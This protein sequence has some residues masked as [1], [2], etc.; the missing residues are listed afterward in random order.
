MLR[1]GGVRGW[2][3]LCYSFCLSNK[4]EFFCL[5]YVS[6]YPGLSTKEAGDGE[7]T[8]LDKVERAES[9]GTCFN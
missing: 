5:K 7:L 6:R 3:A 8:H 9:W 1:G 4:A 2:S